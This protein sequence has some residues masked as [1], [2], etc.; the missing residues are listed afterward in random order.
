MLDL[1]ISGGIVVCEGKQALRRADIAMCGGRIVAVD[2]HI[3]EESKA[4]LE[5]DGCYVMAGFIDVHSHTD[6]S[7][8]RSGA[9]SKL[10]QGVTTEICGQCG[11][12]PAPLS[13]NAARD[14]RKRIKFE[15]D[16][17]YPKG[18][19]WRSFEDLFDLLNHGVPSNQR[20]FAGWWTVCDDVARLGGGLQEALSELQRALDA[21]SAGL[22]IH[23][24]SKSW[25]DLC[26]S[27]RQALFDVAG[28]SGSIVSVH[29]EYYDERSIALID[30]LATLARRSGVRLQI[31]HVKILGPQRDKLI[32]A[33]FD[34]ASSAAI[35]FDVSPFPSICTR[36][37]SILSRTSEV[38]GRCYLDDFSSVRGIRRG[39]TISRSGQDWKE[40]ELAALK[41]R[42]MD[43]PGD[44]VI[45]EGLSDVHIDA[46]LDHPNCFVGTD[47]SAVPEEERL[48]CHPR[49]FTTFPVAIRR[50]LD[51]GTPLDRIANQISDAPARW[52]GLMDR[53]RIAPG[54]IADIV[55]L[56][57]ARKQ[58]RV[59]DVI[60]YGSI[61]VKN[62]SIVL[63]NAGRPLQRSIS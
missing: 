1:I 57:L 33:F 34:V 27:E 51:H 14:H 3:Y 15:E 26:A 37:R 56:D 13:S 24:E 25:R 45:A 4:V 52:F 32:E 63:V 12:A 40:S 19:A 5:A 46:L 48:T 38:G 39:W 2:E 54:W 30:E 44:L 7:A 16:N 9:F 50:R 58:P 35:R 8:F 31:S 47:S 11:G 20:I 41:Q 60:I 22:S 49:A 21:G 36:A 55:I 28:A 42:A 10:L 59:R 43:A 6:E 18:L 53:G 29:L 17:W 62:G 61:A 23:Q